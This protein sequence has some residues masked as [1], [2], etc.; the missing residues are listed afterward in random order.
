MPDRLTIKVA[1]DENWT[2]AKMANLE[3]LI[4]SRA[5]LLKKVLGTD[6]LPVERTETSLLFG[7]FPMDDNAE[8]YNQL[9]CALVRTAME[10]TRITARERPCESEQTRTSPTVSCGISGYATK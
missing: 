8:V 2:P 3:K 9:V 6:A 10:A 4:G 7:W 5:T 1:I